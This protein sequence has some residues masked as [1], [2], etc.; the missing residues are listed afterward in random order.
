MRS[1]EVTYSAARDDYHP[2][3]H[4]LLTVPANY[5]PTNPE[6]WIDHPDWRRLWARAYGGLERLPQ[7]RVKFVPTEMADGVLNDAGRR[8]ILECCKY[9]VKPDGL[10]TEQGDGSFVG[11]QE[12]ILAFHDALFKRRQL[13]FTGCLKDVRRELAQEDMEGGDADLTDKDQLVPQGYS[14]LRVET[15]KWRRTSRLPDSQ[16]DLVDVVHLGS[17][18]WED[19]EALVNAVINGGVRDG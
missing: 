5:A 11:D 6:L 7:V 19:L 1:L 3:V 10:Y 13:G 15:Y 12:V 18:Q 4:C 16:F 8:R 9:L 14:A 17:P 2:H